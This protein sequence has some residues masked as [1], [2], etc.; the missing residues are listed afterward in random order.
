MLTLTFESS[1]IFAGISNCIMLHPA[2][3]SEFEA[4]RR[5]AERCA[6]GVLEAYVSGRA[7]L[8]EL[9]AAIEKLELDVERKLENVRLNVGGEELRLIPYIFSVNR[10]VCSG[11]L[12]FSPELQFYACK[13]GEIEDVRKSLKKIRSAE[14]RAIKSGKAE[15]VSKVN[16]L[17]GAMLGYPQCCVKEFSRRKRLRNSGKNV[18]SLEGKIAEEYL[19]LGLSE[20]L[21]RAFREG[22]MS[23]LDSIPSSLFAFNFYP[24]S[25]KCKNAEKVGREC[26]RALEERGFS[27][28]FEAGVIAAM[29]DLEAICVKMRKIRG[30][31]F[32]YLSPEDIISRL[33]AVSKRN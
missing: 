29:C 15:K 8:E 16:E 1:R 10:I 22:V 18:R 28:L 4:F 7:G 23:V 11:R 32:V 21:E 26:R 13:S 25:L 17:E 5:T 24:C 33:L 27:L 30:K 19:K 2:N 20:A 12:E 9:R 3:A 31:S 14:L 6:S